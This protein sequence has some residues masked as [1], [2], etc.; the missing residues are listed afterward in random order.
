MSD[1]GEI[2]LR[3]A[4]S[5]NQNLP[6]NEIM[7]RHRT[8]IQVISMVRKMIAEGK[9]LFDGQ[10]KATLTESAA[11]DVDMVNKMAL[12]VLRQKVV[13]K[14]MQEVENDFLLG[15]M[16]RNTFGFR[17]ESAGMTIEEYVTNAMSFYIDYG[18]R[19][20]ELE[21]GKALI[22]TAKLF[23]RRG[24][25]TLKRMDLYGKFVDRLMLMSMR[26]ISIPGE[27]PAQFMDDLRKI[28]AMPFEEIGESDLIVEEGRKQGD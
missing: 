21:Q 24:V 2:I 23:I 4:E 15:N 28:E 13:E 11:R 8:N 12:E 3:V 18:R 6:Q 27:L 20:E 26:G 5:I 7:S 25:T 22:E 9:I 19:I 10:G 16:L 17:A 14:A 1:D